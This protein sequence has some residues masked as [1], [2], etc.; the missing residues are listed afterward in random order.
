MG[1]RVQ[2]TIL[3]AKFWEK[4][5]QVINIH[6]P[7]A[8]VLKMVDGERRAT[9]SYVYEAMMCARKAIAEITP[10]SCKKYLDIVDARWKKQIIRPIHIAA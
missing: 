4:S 9:M 1:K 3:D 2:S 10:K 5:K 7:I 8:K 6:S